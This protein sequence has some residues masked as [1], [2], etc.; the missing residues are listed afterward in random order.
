MSEE[1]QENS[2]MILDSLAAIIPKDNNLQGIRAARFNAPGSRPEIMETI[3]EMGLLSLTVSEENG[4]AGLGMR[5]YCSMAKRLGEGLIPE[6]LITACL[7]QRLTNGNEQ[8]IG[9]VTAWQ[10]LSGSLNASIGIT[11]SNNVING[12]KIA[13]E[14]ALSA[15]Q[16]VVTVPDGIAIVDSNTLGLSISPIE[17]QD[18]TFIG[19]LNFE[20]VKAEVLPKTEEDINHA[21]NE[22]VLAHSAYLLGVSERAFDITLEYLRI[23]EQFGKKIGTFQALQHRATE[24]QISIQLAQA[25]LFSCAAKFDNSETGSKLYSHLSRVKTRVTR[26]SMHVAREVIQMHGAIGFADESDIGLYA[27]KSISVGS[28]Y[29]SI[30][31]HRKLYMKHTEY[32]NENL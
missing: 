7:A 4:G 1:W 26:L 22:A 18:G 16:I 20:N 19:E 17:L 28:F 2:R 3:I 23:R 11:V 32:L 25:A 8:A 14:G 31:C 21:I 13:V 15:K 29:G 9:A 10:G 12:K 6:P 30:E 5:E 24:I 27:R